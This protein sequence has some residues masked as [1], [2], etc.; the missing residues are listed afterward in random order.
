MKS[1]MRTT[2]WHF[3]ACQMLVWFSAQAWN[4]PLE[5]FLTVQ[6]C[7][8]VVLGQT[9]GS[10]TQQACNS[11]EL[12]GAVLAN[13]D[14]PLTTGQCGMYVPYQPFIPDYCNVPYAEFVDLPDDCCFLCR[15]D[16]GCV[17]W[18][19]VRVQDSCWCG[20]C[21]L[22]T[23]GANPSC[24]LNDLG[25]IYGIQ[26][27]S[28]VGGI[29]NPNLQDD[30]HLV[31][32]RGTKYDFNGVPDASFCLVTDRNLHVNMKLAG[33]L[34][35]RYTNNVTGMIDNDEGKGIRTWVRELGFIWR[36]NGTDHTLRLAARTGKMQERGNGFMEAIEID[37]RIM[38]K[39]QVDDLVRADGGLKIKFAALE[40]KGMF[41]VDFF[42]VKVR[43]IFEA[44]IRLR[45]AHPALQLEDDAFAHIN[46]HF[47][48]LE[49]SED[50]HGVL[51]QTYRRDHAKRAVYYKQLL[52]E[53]RK[54]LV[55]DGESGKGFLDG[56]ALDYLASGVLAPD[57]KYTAYNG[58]KLPGY[59]AKD[60]TWDL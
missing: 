58:G 37:H 2:V 15:G 36:M 33:Y 8:S 7:S 27:P 11:L 3:A 30:P 22:Y 51:G 32:A 19:H 59:E 18:Q 1:S 17:Y 46:I 44:E 55:V 45:V 35:H 39:M 4:V 28:R 26:F 13:W 57:C 50:I 16:A 49:D 41:D 53:L 42:K 21:F 52:I 5:E 40:R 47:T 60:D 31:G 14:I 54:P 12:G 34:D 6:D 20:L 9:T 23:E 38:P 29:C 43:G 10:C 48:H 56:T 24:S 25:L